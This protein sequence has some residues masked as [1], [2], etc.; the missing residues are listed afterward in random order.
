MRG[1]MRSSLKVPMITSWLGLAT[2]FLATVIPTAAQE[3]AAGLLAKAVAAFENNEKNEKHWNWNIVETRQLL[4][5]S[6][7]TLQKF[8][9]VTSDR[10]PQQWAPLQ[11][12]DG[13]GRRPRTLYER[14]RS[15]RTMP[16]L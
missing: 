15:R 14:C 8:P 2:V 9:S 1:R 13:L 6:G 4:S 12:T 5:K 11:C 7:E 3:S 16:G 10:D